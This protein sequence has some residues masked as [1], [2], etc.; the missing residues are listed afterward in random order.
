[1]NGLVFSSVVVNTWRFAVGAA[2]GW[3]VIGV[4]IGVTERKRL[5]L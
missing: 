3:C 2:V 1:M 5:K 4:L